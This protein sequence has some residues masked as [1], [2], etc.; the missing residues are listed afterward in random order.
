MYRLS[1]VSHSIFLLLCHFQYLIAVVYNIYLFVYLLIF[2]DIFYCFDIYTVMDHGVLW[3]PLLFRLFLDHCFGPSDPY[4][5]K[6]ANMQVC[7]V[8]V[9]YV[10]IFQYLTTYFFSSTLFQ[11]ILQFFFIS[12][13]YHLVVRECVF[14]YYYNFRVSVIFVQ[15][16][17]FCLCCHL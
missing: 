13:T 3:F 1:S 5:T 9:R 2:W 4:Y 8:F 11:N 10:I 12:C 7:S 15:L 14:R 16:I 6:Y 17:L